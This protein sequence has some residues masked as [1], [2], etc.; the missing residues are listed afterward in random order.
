MLMHILMMRLAVSKRS[1]RPTLASWVSISALVSLI[2]GL[3][4]LW[5]VLWI[6]YTGNT[7]SVLSINTQRKKHLSVIMTL[8]IVVALAIKFIIKL[9]FPSHVY[10]AIPI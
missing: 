3:S 8:V 7:S 10:S 2:M 6:V 9:R 5:L 1:F 4:K